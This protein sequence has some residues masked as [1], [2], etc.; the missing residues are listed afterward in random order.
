VCSGLHETHRAV[1]ELVRETG[2]S[3]ATIS[4]FEVVIRRYRSQRGAASEE[5]G[6][7][8]R[9]KQLVTDLSLDKEC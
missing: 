1:T 5:N 2:I 6:E 9:Q 7:S 4:T 3:E 8:R